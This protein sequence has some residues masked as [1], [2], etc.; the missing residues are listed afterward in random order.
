[1]FYVILPEAVNK[2]KGLTM[3]VGMAPKRCPQL[4]SPKPTNMLPGKRDFADLIKLR[5]LK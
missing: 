3:E 5:D 4:Q 1:M 2:E